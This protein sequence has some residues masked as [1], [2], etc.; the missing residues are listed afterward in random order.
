MIN[1]VHHEVHF[2][3]NRSITAVEIKLK[4][5]PEEKVNEECQHLVAR[6]SSAFYALDLF[7]DYGKKIETNLDIKRKNIVDIFVTLRKDND[8]DIVEL[9]EYIKEFQKEL[10]KAPF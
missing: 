4:S 8:L 7:S 9:A 3:D 5:C 10:D 1:I 2:D 6:V